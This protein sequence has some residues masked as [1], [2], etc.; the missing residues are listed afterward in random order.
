MTEGTSR[1]M[2]DNRRSSRAH[3]RGGLADRPDRIALWAVGLAVIAML[4]AA[5]SAH[6]GTGGTSVSDGG[7]TTTTHSGRYA[8]IWDNL[9]TRDHRWAH[10]TSDCES[11]SDP[12]AVGG[13]GTY[14][15]AFQFTL[16]TWRHAPK[17]P[18]GDPVRYRWR[19]QAVVAVLLKHHEGT[20]P[21]PVCG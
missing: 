2:A 10:R 7:S 17:S 19:T 5:T 14:R 8:R 3:R 4:A 21:W 9:S 6:A 12:K 20:S 1:R 16:R 18:G 13:G 11:G 15:G